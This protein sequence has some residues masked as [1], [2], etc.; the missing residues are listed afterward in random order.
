MRPE[1]MKIVDDFTE[2]NILAL[3]HAKKEGRKIIGFYCGF[4]PLELIWAAGA[5]PV[6]L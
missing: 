2:Q 3:E 4:A 5:I 1:T 6:G